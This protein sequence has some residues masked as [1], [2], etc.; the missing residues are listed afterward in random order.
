MKILIV[1][2]HSLNHGDEAAG[3][4]LLRALKER[5]F[6]DITIQYNIEETQT[7]CFA[8]GLPAVLGRSVRG[9]GLVLKLY[10]RSPCFL[11]RWLLLTF[12]KWKS[13]YQAIRNTQVIINSP[14]GAN[15]GDYAYLWRLYEGVRLKRR[16]LFYSS[17]IPDIMQSG[18][19]F[20]LFR[21]ILKNCDFVSLRDAQSF[22][23]AEAAGIQ[24]E[25]AIDSAYMQPSAF[26]NI[27]AE[28]NSELPRNYVVIVPNELYRWHHLYHHGDA[29]K[30]DVFFEKLILEF[31]SQKYSVVLLPQLFAQGD[32]ND[33]HYFRK[34]QTRIRGDI[35]V[36]ADHYSSDVQQQ[37]IANAEYCICCRYHTVV[38]AIHQGVPFYCLSYEH[39]MKNMLE[40]LKLLDCS[41]DISDALTHP[42]EAIEKIKVNFKE[43][44]KNRN[45]VAHASRTAHEI[46]FRNFEKFI[47]HL[48]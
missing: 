36:V 18:Y 8:T 20:V 43:R 25:Q 39:K 1:N 37:I 26:G 35:F 46:A 17:S 29:Q 3:M 4:A 10:L 14:G 40:L 11:T 34:L 12:P 44:T 33:E 6:H 21:Y 24:A 30:F 32:M 19:F 47:Q 16:V 7:G 48:K 27:P 38:F 9:Q 23:F 41:E 13:Q 15:Y 31:L 28:L 45:R 2:Q 42:N 5:G 22:R